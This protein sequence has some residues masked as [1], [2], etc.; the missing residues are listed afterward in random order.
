MTQGPVIT[1]ALIALNVAI[2]L[3]G[4]S[5][6]KRGGGAFKRFVFAPFETARGRNPESV[7]LAQFSHADG[8]HL[9]FNMLTLYIFGRVVERAMGI[10][11]LTLYAA[12]GLAATL[13]I[14]LLRRDNPD[15]RVLGASGSVT[16]ILFAAIVI[17]PGMSITLMILPV[18][19]IPAPLFAVL[20]I[21]YSTFL[22]DKQ[23]GNVAH[24]AHIA[25]GLAGFLL[26]GFLYPEHFAPLL[27]RVQRLLH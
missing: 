19:P 8:W 11:M 6:L 17:D 25:G 2:S 21:L 1:Y 18:F 5:A 10:H 15:Y 4:F 27:E 22:L 3:W 23:V 9:F 24:E 16:G 20:Y 7:F 13:L 14:F 26:A 12:S